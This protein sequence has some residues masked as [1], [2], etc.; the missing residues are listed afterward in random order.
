MFN[1]AREEQHSIILLEDDFYDGRV[2]NLDELLQME[3]GLRSLSRERVVQ[4]LDMCRDEIEWEKHE[5]RRLEMHCD[6]A[7]VQK[8]FG[9][10]ETFHYRPVPR[11]KR[12]VV[13][14]VG[15]L[16]PGDKRDSGRKRSCG[17]LCTEE[18]SD[19]EMLGVD[20]GYEGGGEEEHKVERVA[21]VE[22]VE[23]IDEGIA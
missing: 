11:K 12:Y 16:D 14:G 5:I 4:L 22:N 6:N 10:R 18:T 3:T 2:L 13:P 17:S 9:M 20:L 1:T 23:R 21:K 7:A 8:R 15:V 19:E